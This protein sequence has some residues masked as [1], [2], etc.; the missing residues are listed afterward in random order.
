MLQ[1]IPSALSPSLVSMSLVQIKKNILLGIVFPHGIT[2]LVH[3]H[4]QKQIPQLLKLNAITLFSCFFMRCAK[5]ESIIQTIFFLLSIIHFRNDMPKITIKDI[6]P[7]LTQIWLSTIINI[8]FAFIPIEIFII[9]ITFIHTVNHYKM[10]WSFLKDSKHSLIFISGLGLILNHLQINKNLE[11]S[12][13]F[14][15]ESTPMSI[16]I[17]SVVISHIIYQE[18][19]VFQETKRVLSQCK[20][21]LENLLFLLRYRN[22]ILSRY[23]N[24]NLFI[25]R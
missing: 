16:C 10:S 23:R 4:K 21:M 12:K 13:S 2:D 22:L 19:Y 17:K 24:L 9:Y 18:F 7:Q 8:G 25:K 3:A 14:I 15:T 20:K 6:D 11:L 1:I 5:Q